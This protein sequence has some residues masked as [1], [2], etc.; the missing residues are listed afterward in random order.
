[1]H[2]PHPIRRGKA[3]GLVMRYPGGA[4]WHR[5]VMRYPG[6]ARVVVGYPG[7]AGWRRLA[8]RY[9]GGAALP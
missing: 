1:M 7:G 4:G 3:R 2:S 9:P 8:M 6:G 5:L